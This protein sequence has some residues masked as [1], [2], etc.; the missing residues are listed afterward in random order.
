MIR[1]IQLILL[2]SIAWV[3]IFQFSRLIF[4]VYQYFENTPH[5]ITIL[6]QSSWHGIRMD[7]SMTAY[8]MV[9]PALLLAGSAKSWLWYRR[10]LLIYSGFVS[11]LCV[12]L[13]IIDLEL[14]RCWGTRIDTT[15]LRYLVNPRE[16]YASILSSPL[17]TLFSIAFFWCAIILIINQSIVRYSLNNWERSHFWITPLLFLSFTCLLIIPIRGGIQ[18]IPMNQ[19]AVYY[20]TDNFANQVAINASWNFFSSIINDSGNTKNPF[21]KMSESNALSLLKELNPHS[22]EIRYLINANSTTNVILIIW[23][24]FTAK[25]VSSLGGVQ[26]VTPM[27]D[28]LRHEGILFTNIYSSGDRSDK[29]LVALLSGYPSQPLTSIIKT[30]TKTASLPS[31]PSYFKSKG[32]STSF[33]YGGETEFANIKSYLLQQ[34]YDRIVDKNAFAPK[35]M[36]SKWGAHDHVVLGRLLHD[37]DQQK[38]PFFTTLFT[39]S[40]H[41]PFEV[42]VSTEIEGNDEEHKFLNSH[43]YTDASIGK[44]LMEAKSKPWWKNTLILI[45]ADHGHPLP[46]LSD[47][48]PEQFHIPMLWLGGVVK[49]GGQTIDSLGS[50]IDIPATLLSQLKFQTGDFFKSNNLLRVNRIPYAFYA[51]NNGFGLMKP[52]GYLVYDNIGNREIERQGTINDHDK[53]LGQAYLQT[54]YTD[55]LSR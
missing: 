44:F 14:Y 3:L 5:S 36:N 41:E 18:Q 39:L 27:F 35:D 22:D 17:F 6:M 50:Q 53:K 10:F 25:V 11:V 20:S 9:L 16:V 30:P 54:L 23:E 8:L 12:I 19:S 46:H 49:N 42:P 13:I 38:S 7:I 29:G 55:F 45:I 43:H 37:L 51:F 31:L 4:F 2:M 24:S 15:P 32:Y 26:N 33:Y 34:K 21:V 28:S 1:R 40:S 48:K 52:M 47:K